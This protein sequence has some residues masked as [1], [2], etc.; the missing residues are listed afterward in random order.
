V[1]EVVVDE[2]VAEEEGELL[3][4]RVAGSRPLSRA[5][6]AA[7]PSECATNPGDSPAESETPSA[8]RPASRSICGFMGAR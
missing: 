8:S 7:R 3:P 2:A 5:P 6:A 1:G 4:D